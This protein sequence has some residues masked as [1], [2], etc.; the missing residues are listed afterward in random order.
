MKMNV[1]LILFALLGCSVTIDAS[2]INGRVVS[3]GK[4]LQNIVVTDGFTCVK[5]GV[6]GGYN[7][8]LNKD[9]RFVYISTPSGYLPDV[10]NGT[11]P[12]FYKQIQKGVATYDFEL[13]KNPKDDS[14]HMFIVQTDV[15]VSDD[16]DLALYKDLLPYCADFINQ[17]RDREI[18]G[19]DCGD[20]T[21]D[22]QGLLPGYI[23]AVSIL[24]IPIYRTIGNHDM[25]YDGRTHEM[26]YKT[27]ES[28]FGPIYYSFNKGDAH[29]IAINNSFFVGREY[30]YMGY[31]DEKTFNWLEQDLSYVEPG[32][33]VFVIVHIPIQ[34]QAEH[35]PFNYAPGEIASQTINYKSLYTLLEPYNAHIIS[36]HLH[37]AL[38][39]Y[40]NDRLYE[41][42][43]PA[44]SGI[45]WQGNVCLDGSPMGYGV[46]EVN[47]KDVKWYYKGFKEP[48][49]YQFKVYEQG[50]YKD[51]PDDI[52][53]N[54]WNWDPAWKVEWF[55]NGVNK[56]EMIRFED[57]D[58]DAADICAQEVK[59]GW[60]TPVKTGNLFKATPGKHTCIKIRVTDRFGEVFEE[61]LKK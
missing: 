53:V 56:G 17:N 59:Y 10:K 43:T 29:Y 28:H 20:I 6:D 8:S 33:P 7:L 22:N 37:R 4:G 51:Y 60:I 12:L 23:D 45:W 15:Q 1:V 18:F 21:G 35:T 55:E 41:H 40:H 38:N 25:D 50:R 30:F 52:I 42:V 16:K 14:S 24:D 49:D 5:T 48:R 2:E 36:G 19:L 26:S 39:V 46:Y 54:V 44:V 32:S 61:E 9:A 3:Q 34:K 58:Q 11:I 27:F 31:I 13:K 47:G 57:F